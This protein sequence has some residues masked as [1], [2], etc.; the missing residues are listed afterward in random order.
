MNVNIYHKHKDILILYLLVPLGHISNSLP[1]ALESTNLDYMVIYRTPLA[2]WCWSCFALGRGL[3]NG[4]ATFRSVCTLQIFMS[5]SWTFSRIAWKH[6]LMCFS[7]LCDL[8]SCT[9]AMSSM[10]SQ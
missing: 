5:P 6:R 7:F 2:V 4:S 3:V 8:G 10:L 9:L 1:L